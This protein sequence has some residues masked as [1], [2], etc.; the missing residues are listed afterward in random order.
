MNV[1]A[2]LENP[3]APGTLRDGYYRLR[4]ESP[5]LRRESS[6]F[7]GLPWRATASG[8]EERHTSDGWILRIYLIEGGIEACIISPIGESET[9]A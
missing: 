6:K 8:A 5:A 9:F 4:Q 7:E 3:R 2:L 1:L